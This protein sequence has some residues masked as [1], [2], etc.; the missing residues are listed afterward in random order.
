M[1]KIFDLQRFGIDSSLQ[2]HVNATS[3]NGHYYYIYSKVANSWE[4]AKTYC[5]NLGGYLASINNAA[6]DTALFNYMKSMG[7]SEAYF[8]LTDANDEGNWTWANG[9]PVKYLNWNK[10]APNGGKS[11]NYG[12]YGMYYNSNGKWNDGRYYSSSAFICEWELPTGL[13]LNSEGNKITASNKF[14]SGEIE[15][16]NYPKVINF[17]GSKLTKATKITGTS[18]DNIIL[19][20]SKKDSLYGGDGNDSL[21]GNAGN[22]KIFGGIGNDTLNGGKGNDTLSGGAGNDV[23]V[24]TGGNDVITDYQAKKDII[25]MDGNSVNSWQVSG[26]NVIFTTDNG[27]ITVKNGKGKKISITTTKVYS[28]SSANVSELFAENN[29]VTAD[30]L[31]AIVKNDL[32]ATDYKIDTQNFENLM[33]KNNL[34][35]FADK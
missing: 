3:Y 19:G 18:E 28:T 11:E 6:E 5:E 33:Q 23:F 2:I 35:T 8:G 7:Y 25:Y 26:K 14:K 10:G 32:T 27:T 29:F 15:L 24:Y 20:G 12:M 31:S 17:N 16:E 4:N 13:T 1:K 21:A 22:D 34:I 30:N 9:D